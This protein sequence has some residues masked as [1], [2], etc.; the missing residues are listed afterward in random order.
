M[1][2]MKDK[3]SDID[4]DN[5]LENVD[6]MLKRAGYETFVIKVKNKR[7]KLCY[8]IMAK[9]N[10]SNDVFM[11][12]VL[13]NIDNAPSNLIEDIKSMSLLLNSKPL[14]IGLR[15]RYDALEKDTIYTRDGL[16]FISLE[17]LENI[18][19]NQQFP[20]VLARRGGGVVF[21]DGD[22]MKTLRE[23]NKIS[24]K[25][26]S[27]KLNITKRTIC[28]YE[29]E[30][31]CPSKEMA[32][33]IK[34]ILN[35]S[36][37]IRRINVLDWNI[38][39]DFHKINIEKDIELSTFETH[40]QDIIEDIGISSYWYK[41]GQVPFELALFSNDWKSIHKDNFYPLFSGVSE[42]RKKFTEILLNNLHLFSRLFNKR[43]LFIVNNEFKVPEKSYIQNIPFIKIKKLEKIDTEE[44]FVDLVQE[45]RK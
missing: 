40:L 37:I 27:E 12:K 19:L 45:K 5:I 38:R 7:N 39:F 43:M 33:F 42:D 28:A 20:F 13:A 11:V 10:D 24:R 6:S 34:K 2:K 16:P 9:N 25:E 18:L 32:D 31:M 36:S 14:L 22:L 44:E 3:D 29:N 35:H 1:V 8:D 30:N 41:K 23:Q 21:L 15:N 17:T 4:V 26:M